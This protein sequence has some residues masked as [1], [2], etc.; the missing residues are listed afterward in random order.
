MH[1]YIYIHIYYNSN[2]KDSHLEGGESPPEKRSQDREMYPGALGR[3]GSLGTDLSLYIVYVIIYIYMYI[4]RY[5]CIHTTN[6]YHNN[7]NTNNNDNTT[8]NN[9]NSIYSRWPA[10]RSSRPPSPRCYV[11]LYHIML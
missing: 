9:S 6:N 7:D 4:D 1:I 5:Y 3:A 10:V 8:N 2:N 11:I